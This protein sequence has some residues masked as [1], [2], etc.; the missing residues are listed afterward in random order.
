MK[1]EKVSKMKSF[2]KSRSGYGGIVCFFLILGVILLVY[3]FL[4]VKKS[5][6]CCGNEQ[7]IME[8]IA[9]I[10]DIVITTPEMGY[11]VDR[12]YLKKRIEHLR[13]FMGR[14]IETNGNNTP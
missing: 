9:S 6:V 2:I 7:A 10:E 8:V 14:R 12:E 13:K 11:P 5:C 4:P 3:H 1:K